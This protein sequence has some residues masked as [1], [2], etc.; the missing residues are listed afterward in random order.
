MQHAAESSLHDGDAGAGLIAAATEVETSTS[1]VLDFNT[2]TSTESED[3][4]TPPS[5]STQ[6]AVYEEPG[7]DG[8]PVYRGFQDPQ[9]QSQSFKRLQSLISSGEGK[10]N[11]GQ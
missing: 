5:V 4:P 7:E 6:S 1:A 3:L 9:S 11:C 2:R 10:I 8:R